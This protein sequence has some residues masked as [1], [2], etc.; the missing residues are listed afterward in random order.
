MHVLRPMPQ[1]WDPEALTDTSAES[2]Q[3]KC[4]L[5]PYKGTQ[6]YGKVLM[7]L[8]KGVVVFKDGVPFSEAVCGHV[9]QKTEPKA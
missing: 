8:V 7:T 4:K 2:E 1:V 3:H 6:L 5:S 9:L